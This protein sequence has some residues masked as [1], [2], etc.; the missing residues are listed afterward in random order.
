[1]SNSEAQA[2]LL[3]GP[4]VELSDDFYTQ[5]QYK[6]LLQTVA[7]RAQCMQAAYSDTVRRAWASLSF[8]RN[9]LGPILDVFKATS[10]P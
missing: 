3:R 5:D 10:P 1:M 6:V 9:E 4:P 8:L 2:Q 7:T